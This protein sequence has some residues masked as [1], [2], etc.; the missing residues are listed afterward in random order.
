MVDPPTQET[1]LHF[2]HQPNDPHNTAEVPHHA[3]VASRVTTACSP[4]PNPSTERATP[5]SLRLVAT[6]LAAATG[7]LELAALGTHVRL[8]VRVGHAGGTEVL[9][10][11]AAVL[12]AA[13]QHAVRAGRGAHG[14]L[15]EGDDLTTGL[16]ITR[17]AAAPARSGSFKWMGQA[18]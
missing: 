5:Q 12:G 3:Q 14:E 9:Y 15:V 13:Q 16:H 2:T 1:T 10:R 7:R 11:L 8:D 6:G 4:D 17:A 18:V